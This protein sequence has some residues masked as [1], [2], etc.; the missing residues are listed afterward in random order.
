[1][2]ENS[3]N[4]TTLKLISAHD[5]VG[6]VRTFVFETGGLEWIAGQNQGYVLPQAGATKSENE[7]WFTIS[8]APSEGV[9]NISTRISE[10]GFKQA[11]NA[12]R[13]DDEIQTHSLG[14]DFTW[15]EVDEPVVFVAG[16]IGVT[17]FRSILVGRKAQGKP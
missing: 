12:L 11:L 9:V 13:P 16:G 14:G 10:S 7:H 1:M 8:S 2:D 17:P 3:N 15:E 5:E 4:T 6:N